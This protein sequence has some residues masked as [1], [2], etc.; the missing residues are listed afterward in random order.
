MLCIVL[1]TFA[2][3]E[4][5]LLTGTLVPLAASLMRLCCPPL[6]CWLRDTTGTFDF[7]Q[8]KG[9]ELWSEADR[10]ALETEGSEAYTNV[11]FY[12]YVQFILS[13]QMREVHDYA[14]SKGVILKGDI[15][16]GVNR[17]GC[18]VWSEP[19]YFNL[20][21]QAGA[22]PDDFFISFAICSYEPLYLY[23]VSRSDNWHMSSIAVLL[24][25]GWRS[26]LRV[27]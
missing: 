17:H 14:R 23:S 19:R 5:T 22:P 6:I 2:H 10:K 27:M 21:S 20:N 16:I 4:S 7:N 13:S 3:S 9:H 25:S 8:W 11:A 12:Y 24:P 1:S 18:D 15:P 26:I